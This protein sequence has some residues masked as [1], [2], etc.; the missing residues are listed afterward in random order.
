MRRDR[1]WG[2]RLAG[3]LC[4]ALGWGLLLLYTRSLTW[5]E[6]W[7]ELAINV[8]NATMKCISFFGIFLN[9]I[10]HALQLVA[11]WKS[12]IVNSPPQLPPSP[13]PTSESEL[14]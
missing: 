3:I 7:G 12:P 2:I 4:N 10:G 11:H 8:P 6:P 9:I 5:V 13:L 14:C 1:V